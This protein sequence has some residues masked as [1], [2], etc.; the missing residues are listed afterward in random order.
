MSEPQKKCGHCGAIVPADLETCPVCTH[1][2]PGHT[3]AE[4]EEV[5][6][7]LAPAEQKPS[8]GMKGVFCVVPRAATFF[9]AV[10]YDGENG[11]EV[12]EF[13]GLKIVKEGDGEI[14]L[15]NE[16]RMSLVS[17]RILDYVIKEDGAEWY[18]TQSPS[19]FVKNW[20]IPD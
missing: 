19:D 20:S 6:K 18:Q 4:V 3:I 7:T 9:R 2:L 1:L 12:A 10:Q 11:A 5:R 16:S 13:M 14:V 8:K 15:R 17:V